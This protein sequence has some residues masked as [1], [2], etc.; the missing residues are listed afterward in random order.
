M[1]PTSDAS[2][3]MLTK[4]SHPS[5]FGPLSH[6]ERHIEERLR[7]LSMCVCAGGVIGGALYVL[8]S[9]LVPL[10]LAVALSYLLVPVI[11][12]LSVRPLRCF[13]RLYCTRPAP[14]VSSPILRPFVRAVCLAQLP[15]WL[16]TCVALAI[17]FAVLG[18]LGFVVADSVH[19]FA[20]RAELYSH[21]VEQLLGGLIDWMKEMEENAPWY[22][23]TT[24]AGDGLAS[25]ATTA[26]DGLAELKALA[27]KVPVTQL[28]LSVVTSLLEM[29]SNLFLVLLFT[30]YLL[31]GGGGGGGGGGGS[32][33]PDQEKVHQQADAQIFSYVKGKVLVSLLTGA[34][35]ALILFSLH[36]ELWLVFGVLAFWLNFVPNV[37]SVVAVA[38]PMPVVLLD[39]A[40]SG[41]QAALA[42]LLPLGV[43][44]VVGNVVEPLLFGASM[45]MH[46]VVVLCSLMLWG[47]VW[48]ITGMVL[49]V[50]ITAVLRI[51]L[52][53]IDH[54]LFRYLASLLAGGGHAASATAAVAATELRADGLPPALRVAP[55]DGALAA[56]SVPDVEQPP[57]APLPRAPDAV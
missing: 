57:D 22:S 28:I 20:A 13:G 29:L 1:Q 47:S 33:G 7:T 23:N 12:A 30:C 11:D 2:E 27:K 25:N 48:G 6:A 45:E 54:P 15:R 34:L 24:A 41:G 18:L 5:F 8:R 40:F 44:G 50:P 19:V 46:P 31:L 14:W 37:G 21:R 17:A 39:P 10:V 49:A 38:L 51:H 43:H 53:H 32:G 16:A 52:S 42:L 35:T 36:L 56:G 26:A 3:R 9:V 4:V 55:L